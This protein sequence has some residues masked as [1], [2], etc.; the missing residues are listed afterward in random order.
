MDTHPRALTQKRSLV[1]VQLRPQLE[2]LDNIEGF[3]ASFRFERRS[4]LG[5]LGIEIGSLDAKIGK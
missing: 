4:K 5:Q 2:P 1:R 3:L